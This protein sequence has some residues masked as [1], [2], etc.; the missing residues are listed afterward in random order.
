MVTNCIYKIAQMLLV[1]FLCLTENSQAYKPH[2]HKL[3]VLI[4]YYCMW[5]IGVN[6]RIYI[7]EQC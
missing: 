1:A 2:I 3:E 4:T 6:I 7:K 5:Q